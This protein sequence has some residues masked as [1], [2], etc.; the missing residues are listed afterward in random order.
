MN[1]DWAQLMISK[2]PASEVAG[3]SSTCVLSFN[4][5]P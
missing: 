2:N 4:A 1:F 5:V 3:N